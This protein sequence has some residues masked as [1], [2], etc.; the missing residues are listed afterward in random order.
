MLVP[1]LLEA[2]R[3]FGAEL[4]QVRDYVSE[5]FDNVAERIDD[6]QASD[7]QVRAEARAL[8]LGTVRLQMLGLGLVGLGTVLMAVPSLGLS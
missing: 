8:S 1:E 2:E 5:R 7:E 4:Q 6:L 3:A